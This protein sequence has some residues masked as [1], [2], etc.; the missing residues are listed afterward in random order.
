MNQCEVLLLMHQ[1]HR[2]SEAS[3]FCTSMH[4]KC[5]SIVN[6]VFNETLR[7]ENLRNICPGA[8]LYRMMM[9]WI[10]MVAPLH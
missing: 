4:C 9:R 1:H 10:A 3:T 7:Y 8:F 2:D 5:Y 6:E